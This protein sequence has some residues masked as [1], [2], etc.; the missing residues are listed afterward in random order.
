MLKS[1]ILGFVMPPIGLASVA[2]LAALLRGR[3][4]PFGR[5]VSVVSIAGLMLLATPLVARLLLSSLGAG[6]VLAPSP[7]DPPQAIVILGGDLAH[8]AAPSPVDELGPLSLERARAGAVLYRRTG[9]PVLVS[10]GAL[11][12][13]DAPLSGLLAQSLRQ[14]FGVPVRWR[15]SQSEDTWENAARSAVLL[16]A[17]G[18]ASVYLVTHAMHMRRAALAFRRF[19]IRTTPFPVRTDPSPRWALNELV[20][21]PAAWQQSYYAFHEWIGYL[22]Y[23][24]R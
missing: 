21:T 20:P 1:L 13:E 11:D 16:H 23:S 18:I 22:A 12:A 24:L 8:G 10:G 4:A 15:E 19:G 5:A 6:L 3:A 17:A 2:L 9:L 14:D 7:S